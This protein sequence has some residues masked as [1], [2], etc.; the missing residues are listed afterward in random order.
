MLPECVN[1]QPV[2]LQATAECKSD[3]IAD[4]Q[5]GAVTYDMVTQLLG[6]PGVP[7][8]YID[9]FVLLAAECATIDSRR[10]L[11]AR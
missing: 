1:E 8:E 5:R 4:S 9:G 10:C 6:L 7:P 3:P 11:S 2:R